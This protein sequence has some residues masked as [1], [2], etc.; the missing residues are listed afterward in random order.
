MFLVETAGYGNMCAGPRRKVR[1]RAG[2]EGESFCDRM[3]D[4]VLIEEIGYGTDVVWIEHKC[5]GFIKI[6]GNRRDCFENRCALA[7]RP[8]GYTSGVGCGNRKDITD[9]DHDDYDK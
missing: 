3:P 5:S 4:P 7:G 6:S 2:W 8:N 1:R 9:D